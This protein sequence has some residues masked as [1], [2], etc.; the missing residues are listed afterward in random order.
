MAES[1]TITREM[2]EAAATAHSPEEIERLARIA[3]E[4]PAW[5][6]VQPWSRNPWA[7][8]KWT[9]C[10]SAVLAALATGGARG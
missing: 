4:H 1:S 7:R 6:H 9:A 2:I 5:H 8:E 3:Y 10:I